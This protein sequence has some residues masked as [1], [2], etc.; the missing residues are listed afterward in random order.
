MLL[1]LCKRNFKNQKNEV[2][3]AMLHTKNSQNEICKCE[4]P[5]ANDKDYFGCKDSP[6]EFFNLPND[7]QLHLVNWIQN[8]L[9]PIK[10]FTVSKTSYGLKHIYSD[11][12]E[13][14][15]GR[16]FY[17]TNAQFKGAM[18]L[19]GFKVKDTSEQNW[20]F[21]ISKRS[22]IRSPQGGMTIKN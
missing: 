16:Q 17:V 2:K 15:E 14:K 5:W 11:Y 18:L 20:E 8:K 12:S 10:T 22:F 9:T 13:A 4:F 7:R 21:N 1:D 3:K 19:A 6:S